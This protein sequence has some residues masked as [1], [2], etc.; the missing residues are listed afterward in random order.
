M[1][2]RDP[3]LGDGQ[4]VRGSE[5]HRGPVVGT[6]RWV[7]EGDQH[8]ARCRGFPLYPRVRQSDGT[9]IHECLTRGR[10][11][12]E[13]VP[14]ATLTHELDGGTL[15]PQ[16]GDWQEVT[17]DRTY[18]NSSTTMRATVS[19]WARRPSPALWC[20]PVRAASPRL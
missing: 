5:L 7:A 17:A 9:R 4:P 12:G 20:A 3:G 8:L 2:E 14:L 18:S 16:I 19:G 10:R 11:L 6:P 1:Q 15:W 13:I